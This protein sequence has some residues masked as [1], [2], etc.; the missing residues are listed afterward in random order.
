[1]KIIELIGAI[2]AT[3]SFV[4]VFSA[5]MSVYY[6]IYS[7]IDINRYGEA[8]LEWLILIAS[9]PIVI[10]SCVAHTKRIMLEERRRKG[11]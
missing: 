9:L 11:R 1:M 10:Y 2:V 8:E 6:G 3:G 4:T 7:G 5:F